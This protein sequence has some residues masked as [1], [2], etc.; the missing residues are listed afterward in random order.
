MK[1]LIRH[2]KLAIILIAVGEREGDVVI[3]MPIPSL[4]YPKTP[5]RRPA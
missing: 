4:T 3:P 2:R 1:L 5:C